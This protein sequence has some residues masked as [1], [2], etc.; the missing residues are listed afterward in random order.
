MA[1]VLSLNQYWSSDCTKNISYN[2]KDI[3]SLMLWF[4]YQINDFACVCP[5]G[6]DGKDCGH[7]IDDCASSPCSTGST[8]IDKIAGY[9]CICI[10]GMTGKN[11]ET[12]IG[13][14]GSKALER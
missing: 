6:Y 4:F 5:F 3:I 11:C 9:E 2:G 12:D 10:N 1:V 14:Y 7:D 13:E 8:C